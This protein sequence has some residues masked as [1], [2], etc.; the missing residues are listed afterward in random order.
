VGRKLGGDT[1]RT[2]DPNWPK[3]YSMPHNIDLSNNSWGRGRRVVGLLF[4]K[5]AIDG[6]LAGHGSAGG[7]W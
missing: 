3:G 2:G 1:A 6:T 5:V 4:S 7:R